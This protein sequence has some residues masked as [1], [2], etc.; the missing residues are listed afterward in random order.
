M[1]SSVGSLVPE[2]WHTGRKVISVMAIL[3]SLLV[4]M[5]P[6]ALST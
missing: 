1:S 5:D 6:L 3:F 2:N 4:A